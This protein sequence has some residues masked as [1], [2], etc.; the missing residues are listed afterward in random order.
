MPYTVYPIYYNNPKLGYVDRK[1]Y[2]QTLESSTLFGGLTDPSYG[3]FTSGNKSVFNPTV[4]NSPIPIAPWL[5]PYR[6]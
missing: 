4:E 6:A 3:Y 5:P 1:L 2:A